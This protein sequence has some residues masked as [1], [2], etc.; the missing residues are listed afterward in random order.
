[1]KQWITLLAATAIMSACSKQDLR[2]DDMQSVSKTTSES[3]LPPN[4]PPAL[5][6]IPSGV[7]VSGWEQGGNWS[8]QS[9]DGMTMYSFVRM[10]PEYT[11]NAANGGVMI[12]FAKMEAGGTDFEI[13]TKPQR[14]NFTFSLPNARTVK[15]AYL[16]ALQCVGW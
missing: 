11:A 13:Y 14:L 5:R 7:F 10:L 1:M 15:G 2:G 6:V 9:S 8:S 12:T 3:L 16:M 4:H